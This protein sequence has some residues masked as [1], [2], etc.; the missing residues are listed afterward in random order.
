MTE[1]PLPCPPVSDFD[2]ELYLRLI[3]ERMLTDRSGENHGAGRPTIAEAAAALIAVEAID[4]P[5]AESVLDDYSFAT[6][7]RNESNLRRPGMLRA[8][9]PPG[10]SETKLLKPRRVVPC[11]RTI[12][13]AQATM[14]VRYVSL[15]KESTSVAVTWHPGSSGPWGGGPPR[16]VLTDDRGTSEAA[17]FHGGGSNQGMR[18][19]LTTT[20]PLAPDTAWIELDGTR[21]ELTEE[22]SRFAATLERLPAQDPAHQYLWQR[23][24]EPSKLNDSRIEPAIEALVAAGALWAADPLLDEVRAVLEALQRGPGPGVVPPSGTIPIPEP[25]QSLLARDGVQDGPT[26]SIVLGAVPPAFDGFSVAIL[27]LE[28]DENRFRVDVEV[29]PAVGR[30]PFDWGMGPRQLTWWAKDDRDNH[31]LGQR[32]HWSFN[33]DFGHGV[34][35]FHPALDPRATQLELLP[36]AHT[37]RA[38]ISFS[39]PWTRR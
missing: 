25:W 35:D 22:P 10:S 7:L 1:D 34:I 15:S 2:A 33:D 11:A 17:P 38:V 21:L 32:G 20:G 24:A 3:G 37:T 14:Q 31:Y 6:M 29:A 16:A 26:G 19:R 5:S 12:D 13:Q 27:D 18:G 30:M 28:S 39:L 9:P 4:A 36:T 23:I 8:V